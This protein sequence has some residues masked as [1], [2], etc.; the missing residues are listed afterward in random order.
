MGN[1]QRESFETMLS[2]IRA[3]RRTL[4]NRIIMGSMHTRLEEAPE[5]FERK[6][7]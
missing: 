3:G 5:G 1:T 7:A 2:P 4:R 6:A